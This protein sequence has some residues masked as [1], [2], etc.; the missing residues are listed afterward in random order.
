[1]KQLPPGSTIPGSA[2]PG[3][4]AHPC[5]VATPRC[6]IRER[7]R[8]GVIAVRSRR[9]KVGLHPDHDR[10]NPPPADGNDR[11][12]ADSIARFPRSPF[13]KLL[14]F[15]SLAALGA[16]TL[17]AGPAES[18]ILAAMRLSD[19]SNYSWVTTVEDDVR[20]Y[21]VLGMTRRDGFTRLKMPMT[22]AMRRR[23][24]RAA[25]DSMLDVIYHGKSRCVIDTV[26]GWKSVGELP[27]LVERRYQS[28]L[29]A[30]SPTAI[31][32]TM[33]GQFGGALS[34]P[35]ARPRRAIRPRGE[36]AAPDAYSTLK[37]ALNHPHEDLGV[38]VSSHAEMRCEGDVASGTLNAIGALL[39]LVR[40]DESEVEPRQAAGTFKLWMRGGVVTKY[41]VK[42][43][44]VLVLGVRTF[45]VKQ[46]TTTVLKDIGIT[47]FSV[48]DEARL[49]LGE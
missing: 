44:G 33:P 23:L 4:A 47:K 25:M 13:M 37:L 20:T 7:S 30:L 10:I 34:P 22:E 21:D 2:M 46:T 8:T 1:M 43:E 49:K 14:L 5:P 32:L 41:Q 38:I 6:R 28:D 48:P 9:R 29:A 12:I 35:P 36:T 15:P 27:W 45:E 26:D 18:A 16:L 3:S 19:Q 24:G 40:D 39:L 31:G 17:Q 42:L 11:G